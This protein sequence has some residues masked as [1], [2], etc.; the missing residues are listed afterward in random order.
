[1]RVCARKPFYRPS[2]VII[3]K[4]FYIIATDLLNPISSYGLVL[5]RERL[6]AVFADNTSIC[7][8]RAMLCKSVRSASSVHALKQCVSGCINEQ[9][10]MSH[11]VNV[12]QLQCDYE[13]F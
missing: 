2:A 11:C 8:T 7:K 10:C 3:Y 6:P 12:R 5:N 1:M 13:M 9:S 4:T